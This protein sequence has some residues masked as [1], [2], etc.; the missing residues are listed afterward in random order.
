MTQGRELREIAQKIR[1]DIIEAGFHSQNSA[2]FGGCLSLVEIL[3]ALYFK[4]ANIATVPNRDRIILSKGHGALALYATLYERGIISR[5]QLFSFETNGSEFIAHAHRDIGLGLEFSG[6]SLSLGI[7]F[8]MGVAN[9][10]KIKK[11]EDKVYIILGD[12]ELNE[13]LV[14][15]SLMFCVHRHLN[16]VT[17]IVDC[18]GLQ[19]D[20]K[21]AEVMN[22]APLKEKFDSFGFHTEEVDGHD[23]DM[24]CD[25]LFHYNSS[26]RAIIAY[27]TKGFGVSFMENNPKW[28]Y[29]GLAENKYKKA[30]QEIK[31]NE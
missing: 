8:G 3:T 28:H 29:K 26:P 19:I 11:L 22:I 24:L 21:T 15:E 12:G 30:I 20:G 4:V 7:S 23:I 5:E 9:A 27:T 18:N 14:W 2:H 1:L 6:G 10:L 25:A 16:N 31:G 13:G 17:V